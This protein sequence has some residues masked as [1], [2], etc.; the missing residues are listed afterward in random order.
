MKYPIKLIL[1]IIGAILI[2][3][4]S[5]L[6][7]IVITIGDVLEMFWHFRLQPLT[8][9]GNW[10]L[11]SYPEM[12]FELCK[13]LITTGGF[14]IEGIEAKKNMNRIRQWQPLLEYGKD[15]VVRVG[16]EIYVCNATHMSISLHKNEK[17]IL[18]KELWDNFSRKEMIRQKFQFKDG[19][20]KLEG[21]IEEETV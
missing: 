15:Y 2:V 20:C 9:N 16:S 8:I 6:A 18:D 13:N 17:G 4:M 1:R 3:L 5:I 10:L 12:V 21:W 19:F 14:R 7:L 11:K